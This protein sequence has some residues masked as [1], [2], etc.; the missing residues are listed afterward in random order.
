[1][2]YGFIILSFLFLFSNGL[3]QDTTRPVVQIQSKLTSKRT[4]LNSSMAFYYG[5][6]VDNGQVYRF[7]RF[8]YE[9][10][11][12]FC[13]TSQRNVVQ[14][15]IYEDEFYKLENIFQK[16]SQNVD[17][18]KQYPKK[19]TV[20]YFYQFDDGTVIGFTRK[21]DRIRW[22]MKLEGLTVNLNYPTVSFESI[23]NQSISQARAL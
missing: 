10:F 18:A 23:I 22:Y 14:G 9:Y 17:F 19:Y 4:G 21:G 2:R 11:S 20:S 7:V 12:Y 13:G 16:L 6:I 15:Y 1:M 5:K 8:K 3:A